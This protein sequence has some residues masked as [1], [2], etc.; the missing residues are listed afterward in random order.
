M[1]ASVP[2][3]VVRQRSDERIYV[4]QPHLA[5]LSEFLPYL[6]KIWDNK[7]LTNGGPFH[8]QLE[9]ALCDYLG[10][11]HLACLRMARWPS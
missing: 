5:P 1:N 8:Q 6:E 11:Q 4:T 3:H 10:V 9:K 7:V 2:L